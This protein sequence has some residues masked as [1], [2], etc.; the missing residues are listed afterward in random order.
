MLSTRDDDSAMML[1]WVKNATTQTASTRG[2]EANIGE[3]EGLNE[4]KKRA[5]HT[6]RRQKKWIPH[7][8]LLDVSCLAL[9]EIALYQAFYSLLY[10]Y[11]VRVEP[12]LQ[13][14]STRAVTNQEDLQL[15]RDFCH[16]QVVLHHPATFVRM[17]PS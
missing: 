3:E 11:R 16:Q 17:P 9:Q 5:G 12:R 4:R 1:V 10:D 6:R 8:I 2:R 14:R 7:L 15:L 13:E